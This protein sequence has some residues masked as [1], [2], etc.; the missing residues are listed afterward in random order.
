MALLDILQYPDPKLKTIANP[1]PIEEIVLPKFQTIIDNMFETMY[2]AKGIGLAAI[3]VNIPW[4]IITIDL[5]E[6]P[7][8]VL[9]L[10]NPKIIETKTKVTSDEGCL[11]FPGIFTKVA[12]FKEI[13]ISFVDREAKSHNLIATDLLSFCIQHEIDH[14]NGITFFDHLS[15]L[16]KSILNRKLAKI[17]K[18]GS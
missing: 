7:N 11:S 14:L 17:R 15:P 10:I 6:K 2:H 4:Q 1:V 8:Q 5:A 16:K 18:H 12:R 13:E 9:C 3:Q